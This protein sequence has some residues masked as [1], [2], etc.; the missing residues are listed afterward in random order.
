MGKALWPHD[1]ES[2]NYERPANA[3]LKTAF[4]IEV[5][6]VGVHYVRKQY[7]CHTKTFILLLDMTPVTK[8]NWKW[9]LRNMTTRQKIITN[10]PTSYIRILF[11]TQ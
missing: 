8:S 3:T 4:S 6:C 1:T 11:I 10:K 7:R 5:I 2:K 9:T